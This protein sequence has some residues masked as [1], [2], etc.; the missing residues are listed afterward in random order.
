MRLNCFQLLV[1]IKLHWLLSLAFSLS[2]S[3]H[4]HP[5]SRKLRYQSQSTASWATAV[6]ILSALFLSPQTV[7]ATH[8]RAPEK[9]SS[10]VLGHWWQQ[11]RDAPFPFLGS[12]II[13]L[14]QVLWNNLLRQKETIILMICKLTELCLQS[15]GRSSADSLVQ[16]FSE[17]S[18]FTTP[19]TVRAKVMF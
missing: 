9:V 3:E 14:C 1:H 11:P 17:I 2:S 13:Q 6:Q 10:V 19:Y 4:A 15:L 18:P 8:A 7:D 5:D 12:E 16:G